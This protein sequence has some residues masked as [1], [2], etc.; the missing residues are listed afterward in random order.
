MASSKILIGGEA[1]AFNSHLC[2]LL[3]TSGHAVINTA[4]GREALGIAENEDPDIVVLECTLA[5]LSAI[6]VCRLLRRTKP[7]HDLPV[8][9]MT[10]QGRG[11]DPVLALEAGADDCI[12]KPF[13]LR[14]MLARIHAILRRA[15]ME[16]C[17][18]RTAFGDSGAAQHAF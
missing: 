16:A 10:A 15:R 2:D 14:E 8:I 12:L 1:N 17:D 4:C 18:H 7:N 11:T 6:D 5:N 9:V 3:K 13:S